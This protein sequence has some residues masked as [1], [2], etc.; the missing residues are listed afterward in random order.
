MFFVMSDIHGCHDEMLEALTHWNRET[1]TLIVLGDLI[2]RGPDS[3]LVVQTL[4]QL[5]KE[6]PENVIVLSG[7]HDEMLV[8]WLLKTDVEDLA[9]YYTE[10]HT[11]T[12]KSFFGNDD[13]GRKKFRKSS[14]QQRAMHML[15]N[16]KPELQFLAGLSLFHETDHCIFVHAGINLEIP[17]WHTDTKSMRWIRNPFIF[18][19]KVAPKRVFFGH[20][21]TEF[22]RDDKRNSSEWMSPHKDKVGIDGACVFGR[23]L[24]ALRVAESGEITEVVS[25][26]SNQ[27]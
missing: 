3:K 21:P 16:F 14:R 22:I 25:I 7:N 4:M 23:E 5:K 15:H 13:A 19:K 12:L 27:K 1:E 18:S 8:S 11:E 24:H 17:E 6:H 2:D 10:T 20:T 9:F 26:K